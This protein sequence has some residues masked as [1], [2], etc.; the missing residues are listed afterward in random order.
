MAL[1]LA[2]LLL[3]S[4]SWSQGSAAA[5]MLSAVGSSHRTRTTNAVKPHLLRGAV[6][7]GNKRPLPRIEAVGPLLL[8]ELSTNHATR[9]PVRTA[10]TLGP[11]TDDYDY[12]GDDYDAMSRQ[13][14]WATESRTDIDPYS[15]SV[16]LE[17][18]GDGPLTAA[19]V[20]A[21]LIESGHRD[22]Y[23]RLAAQ[24]EAVLLR[25]EDCCEPAEYFEVYDNGRLILTTPKP[26]GNGPRSVGQVVLPPGGMDHKIE[27]KVHSSLGAGV[28]YVYLQYV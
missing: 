21:F 5:R 8:E 11:E 20:T 14:T 19:P 12:D 25:L 27:V 9:A 13:G 26:Q 18:F 2:V 1:M 15:V 16:I 3:L 10:S 23:F 22:S 24:P 6:H 7:G 17:W 4:A 28:G